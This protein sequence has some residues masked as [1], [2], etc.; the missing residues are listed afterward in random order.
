M[1]FFCQNEKSEK[2]S[3][4]HFRLAGLEAPRPCREVVVAATATTT[5]AAVTT[6][7]AAVTTTAAVTGTKRRG[8]ASGIAIWAQVSVY[9]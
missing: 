1:T 8:P 4:S 9:L 6:A 7:V 5:A 2:S 3:T